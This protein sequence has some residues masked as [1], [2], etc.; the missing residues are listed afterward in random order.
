MTA[1]ATGFSEDIPPFRLN[2]A[3]ANV[4]R[5]DLS[6]A[7]LTGADLTDADCSFVNFR[8]ANFR[9][10]K[11]TRTK[12][13]GADLTDAKN[14]TKAQIDEALIDNTTKLPDYL[15]AEI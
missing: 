11:L 9:N 2:V 14:L 6:F 15:L 1:K 3:G 13:I 8:G 10:A 7:N 12:L 4:R 5:T